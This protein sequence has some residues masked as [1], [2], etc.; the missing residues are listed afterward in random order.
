MPYLPQ[1]FLYFCIIPVH[2]VDYITLCFVPV[3]VLVVVPVLFGL[4]WWIFL[5]SIC[6]VVYA[7]YLHF[8][9]TSMTCSSSF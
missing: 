1:I 3:V 8:V 2:M 4:S 6:S 5:H 7:G 9:S